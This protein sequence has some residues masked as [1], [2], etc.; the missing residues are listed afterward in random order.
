[1]NPI[2]VKMLQWALCQI[3]GTA[4]GKGITAALTTGPFADFLQKA[5]AKFVPGIFK[6]LHYQ[7]TAG[8][9]N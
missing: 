3:F 4:K 2:A 8:N 6:A 7:N 1:M 9:E 5:D